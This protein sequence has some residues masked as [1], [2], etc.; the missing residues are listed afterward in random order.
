M[1]QM[2]GSQALSGL[3]I[4][5]GGALACLPPTAREQ[6]SALVSQT[7][8]DRPWLGVF[9]WGE[10]GNIPSV[11]NLHSNLSSGMVL[12]PASGP[13]RPIE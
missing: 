11:G 7:M 8:K 4:Y 6:M 12:F 5:C 10:Q 2:D 9:T 13:D 1:E 3:F